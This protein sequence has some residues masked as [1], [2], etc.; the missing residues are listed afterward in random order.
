MK[1]ASIRRPCWLICAVI[2]GIGAMLAGCASGSPN[3]IVHERS[4]EAAHALPVKITLWSLRTNDNRQTEMERKIEK[5]NE[6]Q[7]QIQVVPYFYEIESYKTK[8]KV[9]MISGKM[10]DLF[11]YWTGESFKYMVDSQIVADLTEYI[12]A[13]PAFADSFYPGALHS[14]QYYD[15]IYGIPYAVTHVLIW[16]NK[17]IFAELQ[18]EVPQTWDQ[19]LHIVDV[20]NENRIYPIAVSG[21]ERWPL[22]H[23][24]AYLSNRTGGSSPFNRALKGAGDFTDASFVEAA[25]LFRNLVEKKA[26]IPGFLGYDLLAA[27]NAF[28]SGE[29]AMYLQGD[30]VADKLLKSGDIGYFPFPVKEITDTPAEYYGGYSVGWAIARNNKQADAYRVL[31]HLMSVPEQTRLVELTGSPSTLNNLPLSAERIK[32]EIYDYI[33]FVNRQPNHFFGFYEQELEPRR[34]QLLLDTIVEMAGTDGMDEAH[35]VQLLGQIR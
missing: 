1:W 6:M 25:Q 22:L 15:R 9:A 11:H 2:V 34:A 32:P 13:D 35:I 20:L 18:L 26:F 33:E 23:W 12:E 21:K 27:E 28:L 8:L 24:Y 19:L 4:V 16:Y 7:S 14:A 30:W 3:E 10:P 5:F 17:S 29:A 31:A